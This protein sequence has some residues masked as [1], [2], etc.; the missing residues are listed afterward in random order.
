MRSSGKYSEAGGQEA[1][2]Q[3]GFFTFGLSGLVSHFE[4]SYLLLWVDDCAKLV[5]Q[6]P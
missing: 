1:E 6:L 2:H 5:S 4:S 3:A